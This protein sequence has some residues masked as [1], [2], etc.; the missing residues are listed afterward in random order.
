MKVKCVQIL[1]EDT[2]DILENSSWL[3]I[4]R[5]Y[6][7]LSVNMDDGSPLK[8]QLIG[9]DG[10]SPAYHDANQFEVVCNEI[11]EDWIIDFVSKSYLR[12]F[13]KAWSEPGF[14]E[15]YFDGEPEAVNLFNK[16]KDNILKKE[17]VM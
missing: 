15:A 4:G 13:P 6:H 17:D 2:G 14:W 3:S 8:F 11:P 7:V 1:D 16:V 9:D 12:L 10:Q 5:E